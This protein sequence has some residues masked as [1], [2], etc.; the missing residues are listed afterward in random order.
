MQHRGGVGGIADEH[1]IGVVRDQ[2]RVEP[3]SVRLAEQDPLD[4]M[5]G[6]AQRRL[7]FG[8]LRVHHHR[9]ARPAQRLGEQHEGL[10]GAGGEQDLGGV[11]GVPGSDRRG[12]RGGV[13][14]RREPGQRRGD[15]AGEPGRERL[16]AHVHGEIDQPVAGLGVAVVCKIVV[17]R[18][19]PSMPDHLL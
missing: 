16:P 5:P 3:E 4:D 9:P 7:R 13:R 14:V 17:A 19:P 15:R 12:G 18:H 2:G 1:Q 10:G 11:A 8:E 6:V